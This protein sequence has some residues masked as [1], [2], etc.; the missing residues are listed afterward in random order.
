MSRADVLENNELTTEKWSGGYAIDAIMAN[1]VVYNRT[2][3]TRIPGPVNLKGISLHPFITM[4][5]ITGSISYPRIAAV[6]N[7]LRAKPM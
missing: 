3:H 1:Y 2:N 5:V 7:H 4:V 6:R